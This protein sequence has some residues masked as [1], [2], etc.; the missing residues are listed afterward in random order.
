MFTSWVPQVHVWRPVPVQ[1]EI[2]QHLR[3]SVTNFDISPT[4]KISRYIRE[5][6]WVCRS[7][8]LWE[9]SYS[10]LERCHAVKAIVAF[11]Q[12]CI[13][14]CI[15]R[16]TTIL[17]DRGKVGTSW[18]NNCHFSNFLYSA[19]NWIYI[20][21]RCLFYYFNE[22]KSVLTEIYLY[23]YCTEVLNLFMISLRTLIFI[24]KCL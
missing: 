11:L 24:Y 3:V 23:V 18:K 20:A 5:D 21:V 22:E 16:Y 7:L 8:T 15:P 17:H 2:G 14:L 4:S 13:L 12:I 9:S 1:L 6:T 10:S 19:L